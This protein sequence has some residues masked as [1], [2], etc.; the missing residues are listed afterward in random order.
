[1]IYWFVGCPSTSDFNAQKMKFSIKDFFSKCD[2]ICSFLRIWS[3]LLKKSLIVNVIFLCIVNRKYIFPILKDRIVRRNEKNKILCLLE[4]EHPRRSFNFGFSKGGAYS[5]EVLFRW[6][7]SLN[8]SNRHQNTFNL[9]LW[10]N[11]KNSNRNRRIKFLMFKIVCQRSL[12]TK[13]K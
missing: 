7:R 4:W 13:E 11:H 6:R 9:F 3:H 10:W 8:I 5:E 1:M 2:Q 12:F